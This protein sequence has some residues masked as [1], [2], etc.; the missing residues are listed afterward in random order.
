MDEVL[1][2][3]H[4]RAN[5]LRY[6]SDSEPGIRRRRSGRGF[7][8]RLPDGTLLRDP[9]TLSRIKTLAVPPAWRDVW[10]CPDP[11]GHI[12]ATGL[13]ERG[14]KQYRYHPDWTAFRDEAKYG[15]LLGFSAALPG[16]RARVEADLALRGLPREKAVAAVIHLLDETLIRVGNPEYARTND[17]YG[18]TTLTREHVTVEGETLRFA[19]T[20]KSG[21]EWRLSLRD[22]RIARI[23][24]SVED[25]PG[26]PLLAYTAEDGERRPVGSHDVNA[27]IHEHAGEDFSAKDFRTW[28]GTILALEVLAET[29]VPESVSGRR[30]ALNAAIDTVARRLGNT[31]AVCRRCYIHPAILAAWE[32]GT[33][34]GEIAAVSGGRPRK[35]LDMAETITARWLERLPA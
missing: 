2:R 14:R 15:N 22:R 33:L 13:D 29:P 3:S 30:R 8:Y 17:S 27:Y 11:R 12:Q 1:L 19:F 20:G 10:I 9:E 16:L 21:K 34:A 4:L 35:G 31:R 28:G 7:S 6:V 25:I 23:V 5:G 32:A 24:K 18:L 26:Q